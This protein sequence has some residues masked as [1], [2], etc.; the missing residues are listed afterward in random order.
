PD[1]KLLV[2]FWKKDGH[3]QA[4]SDVVF[5]AP[6][7][8]LTDAKLLLPE[9]VRDE[10]GRTLS[11]AARFPLSVRFDEAPP[12]VKFA[13][14]FGILEAQE[15]GVLPV[16]VRNVEPALEG[17]SLPVSGETLRVEGSDGEI[18]KW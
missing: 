3:D 16:T 1:G 4:V 7:P 15:G 8:A 6:L 2:P 5:K 9:G 11:N 14:N 13:A 12:L 10:S 18:A 17:R